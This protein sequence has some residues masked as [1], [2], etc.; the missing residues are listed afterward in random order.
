MKNLTL[1][2]LEKVCNGKLYLSDE[3]HADVEIKNV[4][5]DSRKVEEGSLFLAIKGEKTDG[6]NYIQAVL[7]HD[8]AG[9]ICERIPDDLDTDGKGDFLVVPDVLQALKEIAEYYRRGL[10]IKVVGITG[11]VGKT[12]TKEFIAS[13]LAKKYKVCKTQGN[14][15]NE[16]GVPL[17]ILQ[18]REDDEIAVLEM[19]MNHFGEMHRLSQMARPDIC[20]MTNIGQCHLEFLGSR[21]GILKAKSEIFDFWN[22]DGSIV[23]NGDDDKLQTIKGVCGKVPIRFGKKASNDYYMTDVIN[24]GL[25]GSEMKIIGPDMELEVKVPLPG[26]HMLFNALAATAVGELLDLTKEQIIHGLEEVK[27]VGG[28][29][30]VIDCGDYIIIDDCYNANPVSM[31]AALDLLCTAKERKVAILGDMFEL[32]TDSAC[33]HAEVGEYA[34]QKRIDEIICI[35]EES[36]HMSQAAPGSHYFKT[37]EDAMKR[38]PEI[39]KKGDAILIKAS[40]GMN[41]KL[42]VDYFMNSLEESK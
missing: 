21:E 29:S 18:I 38:I 26:E 22:Q 42:I 37:L 15:N 2:N 9:V 25:L 28:R 36:E 7:N 4:V 8:A 23:V 17:T 1:K 20:V 34:Y 30:N 31:K 10:N 33:M 13:V 12:T 27:S 14:F 41:F 11:S 35:G 24:K 32:G 16:I 5:T 19:G 39:L 40:H 6:H 3:K